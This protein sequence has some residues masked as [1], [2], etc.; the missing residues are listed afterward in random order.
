ML[1]S[2]QGG[3]NAAPTSGAFY[4]VEVGSL[5]DFVAFVDRELDTSLQP[6]AHHVRADEGHG[7]NWGATLVSRQ[8]NATRARY[9][10]AHAEAVRNMSRYLTAGA[11]MMRVIDDL[12]RTYRTGEQL[13]SLTP[14]QVLRM[15]RDAPRPTIDEVLHRRALAD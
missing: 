3:E 4:A 14:E 9:L 5:A 13:A 7:R 8:V 2:R 12:M 11:V 15:L 6:A 10:D 1:E